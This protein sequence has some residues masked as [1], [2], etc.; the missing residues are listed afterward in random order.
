MNCP[1]CKK[2][3]FVTDTKCENMKQIRCRKCK[4]CGYVF[5][6]VETVKVDVV[7][8]RKLIDDMHRASNILLRCVNE[9][10]LMRDEIEF[11]KDCRE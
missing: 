3:T 7:D 5:T 1:K 9:I 11:I 4:E 2:D 10:N 8:A 6:T